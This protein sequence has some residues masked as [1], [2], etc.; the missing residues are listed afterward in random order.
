MLHKFSLWALL[1]IGTPVCADSRD[2]LI[3]QLKSKLTQQWYELGQFN[4]QEVIINVS[5]IPADYQP[6]VCTSDYQLALNQDLKPGRNAVQVSCPER[7]AWQLNLMADLQV[8]LQVVVNHTPLLNKATINKQQLTLSKRNIAQL[9][10]G[11][12]TDPKQVA[13]SISRRSLKP[14]TTITPSMIEQPVLIKRG[15]TITL[16]ASNPA[17]TVEMAGEA[18][19]KGRA[20]ESIKVRNISSGKIVHGKVISSELVQIQ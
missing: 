11:Y 3:Q 10:R 5:G 8:W 17:V 1:L 9:H 15:Q 7:N 20:G 12:F 19:R 4:E 14:G 16:R 13:G 6:P 18:M 2:E